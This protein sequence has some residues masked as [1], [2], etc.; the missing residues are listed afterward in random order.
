MDDAFGVHILDCINDLSC[1]ILSA[2]Y[3]QR[4]NAGQ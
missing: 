3:A 1:V 4:S 2:G